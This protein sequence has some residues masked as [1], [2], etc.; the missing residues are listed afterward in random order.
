[1]KTP[2]KSNWVG[3][4]NSE[5]WSDRVSSTLGSCR[6]QVVPS[7]FDLH[8]VSLFRNEVS[9][10]LLLSKINSNL[11]VTKLETMEFGGFPALFLDKPSL[12]HLQSTGN[13]TQLENSKPVAV[14]QRPAAG[15]GTG[16]VYRKPVFWNPKTQ[17][18]PF[19]LFPFNQDDQV[20]D[21][22][23]FLRMH[24]VKHLQCLNFMEEITEIHQPGACDG[25]HLH[26]R[27]WTLSKEIKVLQEWVKSC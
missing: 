25:R 14:E 9:L 18:A 7:S 21:F 10:F 8:H 1:M 23:L 20:W 5:A 2:T 3:N 11:M 22:W 16:K 12:F 13:S 4:R 17:E 24:V 26:Q 15:P 6:L 19:V 27:V